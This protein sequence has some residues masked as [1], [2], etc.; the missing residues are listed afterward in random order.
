MELM[1]PQ[2]QQKLTI[3]D[4]FA[5][6]LMRCPLCNGTFT[7]PAL[8]A[9]PPPVFSLAP[10][11]P[12]LPPPLPSAPEP[13]QQAPPLEELPPPLP[14]GDYSRSL[15]IVFS[16][17]VIPWIT[18]AGLLF[19]FLL[20][21][22]SWLGGLNAW[23]LAFGGETFFGYTHSGDALFA[24]YLIFA[25]VALMESIPASLFALGLAPTPPFVKALGPW[26]PVIAGGIALLSFVFLFIRYLEYVFNAAPT[27]IWFKLT[28]RIHVLVILASL[29]EF[30]LELRRRKNLPS[31][32]IEAHW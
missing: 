28:V 21:F 22:M 26:R 4:Q 32:R 8:S 11:P 18:P 15:K 6:Q 31:P 9:P 19:I 1:C 17:N 20:S 12:P 16:P 25:I 13:M 3:P 24:V 5:G 7:A 27:T 14:P 10:E 30:W 23:K 29:V 2:C